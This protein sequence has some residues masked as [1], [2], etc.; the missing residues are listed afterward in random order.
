MDLLR[1][2]TNRFAALFRRK[3]LDADLDEELRSHIELAVE[4]NL[5]RGMSEQEALTA[6]LR[7]FGGVTQVKEA[8]RTERGLPWLGTLAQ[9]VRYALRQVKKSPGFA[10]STVLTLAL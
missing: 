5:E 10:L 7:D 8:Y 4:E 1:I 9:D 3:K 2:L 6:A